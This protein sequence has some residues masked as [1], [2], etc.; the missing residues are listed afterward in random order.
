MFPD[1]SCPSTVNCLF[2]RRSRALDVRSCPC[3]DHAGLEDETPERVVRPD[4]GADQRASGFPWFSHA[5]HPT[6][7]IGGWSSCW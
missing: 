4:V 2:D 3:I 1:S 7:V 6:T 5:S